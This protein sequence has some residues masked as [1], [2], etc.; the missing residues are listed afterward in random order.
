MMYNLKMMNIQMCRIVVSSSK[1]TND[2]I[3][4]RVDGRDAYI[5]EVTR[6]D[7]IDDKIHLNIVG[8][9]KIRLEIWSYEPWKMIKFWMI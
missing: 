9:H 5:S 6:N 7:K 2:N 3:Y 8:E 1:I 4:F